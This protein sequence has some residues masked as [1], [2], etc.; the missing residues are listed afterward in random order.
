MSFRLLVDFVIH[1]FRQ[2]SVASSLALKLVLLSTL[3]LTLAS[4]LGVIPNPKSSEIRRKA[5]ISET[6]AITSSLLAE[7]HENRLM[8]ENLTAIVARYPDV[9]SACIRTADGAVIHQIGD[10]ALH[11]RLKDDEASTRNNIC[12]PVMHQSRRW[13][14]VEVSFSQDRGLLMTLFQQP[15]ILLGIVSVIFN[16]LLFRWYLGRA[17]AYLDPSKSV[18]MHVR[19]TLDTFAEGVVVL[20]KDQKIVLAN[21]KFKRHVGRSDRELLGNRIDRLPWQYESDESA[22][23]LWDPGKSA[24]DGGRV[25]LELSQSRRTYLVNSSAICGD[26]GRRR[27]TIASFDDITLLENKREELSRMLID[28]KESRDELATR[29]QELKY[30]ATRDSLTGCLNRRTFF[31]IFDK[32][33]EAA[34]Q[35]GASLSCFMVDVD[36]FKSVNDT[37]GHSMGD[38][39]LRKVAHVM[40]QTARN[41][42]VVC[43]YGGEEFCLLL[44]ET[45]ADQA[46]DAAER[47]RCAIEKIEFEALS[48]TAS[49]GVSS[50][51][52]GATE[53]QELLDQADKCLYVA[54]RNGRNQVIRWDEVPEDTTVEP[55]TREDPHAHGDQDN[56][57][58]IP[59]PAVASLLSALAYRDSAT[60]AHSSRVAELCV[61]VATG[62]VSVRDSYLI[63][64]AALLHDIGKI[65]VPDAILLK[66]GSLTAAEW[67]IMHRHDRIGVEIVKAAF[68]NEKLVD[69][70]RFH[71][72]RYSGTADAPWLPQGDSIPIG[73]RILTIADAFDAMVSDRVYRKGRDR[74]EAFTELR[75]CAGT[76]FDPELVERFVAVVREHKPIDL[77]PGS[78][79]AAL[80]LGLQIEEL[81]RALDEQD[82]AGIK[83]LAARLQATAA[84]GGISQIERV[85]TELTA[86]LGDDADLMDVLRL[87]NELLELCR[88]VQK[89]YVDTEFAEV[90]GAAAGDLLAHA[91]TTASHTSMP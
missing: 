39:V 51:S 55:T 11:W 85:A 81:V 56:D 68:A 86:T 31:E 17:L 34:R 70:V 60:A 13:G 33:W 76:Q 64:V 43:R 80:Q 44:P 62:L 10:H 25:S 83:S 7:Q 37:F 78:K 9:T 29:N 59:Y 35:S 40:Q 87:V 14:T 27:G 36:H 90:P 63:E 49:L 2:L 74:D 19:S 84:R 4:W 32:H 42:D 66:P 24:I 5:V 65:G 77:K 6:L 58:P 23:H 30:L 88:S 72:I 61:A 26:D 21:D 46:W 18:P 69:I 8:R 38:E 52:F 57:A 28:L 48:V 54:K 73:A 75:R 79:E 50:I 16:G 22:E 53:P 47:I 20:D 45:G 1:P 15:T 91:C 82:I 3:T 89:T 71:H 12:V 67:E 41:C